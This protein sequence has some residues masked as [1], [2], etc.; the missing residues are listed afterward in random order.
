MGHPGPFGEKGSRD[1]L[2]AQIE[3]LRKPGGLQVAA[4]APRLQSWACW[5]PGPGCASP[6]GSSQFVGWLLW[7]R[8]LLWMAASL[9]RALSLPALQPLAWGPTGEICLP[10]VSRV[11]QCSENTKTIGSPRSSA[12]SP[13]PG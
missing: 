1:G 8:P 2:G 3:C 9:R 11:S 13:S 10:L 6:A 5:T 7:I 4:W 12:L